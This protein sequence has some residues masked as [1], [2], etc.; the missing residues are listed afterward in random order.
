MGPLH[1]SLVFLI[2]LNWTAQKAL[3]MR[4]ENVIACFGP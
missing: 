4:K 3:A 2:V 1:G